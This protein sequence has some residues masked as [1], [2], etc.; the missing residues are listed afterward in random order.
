M[1]K[2]IFITG[3]K[4]MLATAIEDYYNRKGDRVLAPVH[5]ELDVLNT[6]QLKKLILSFK[7]HY[8]F[9]TAALHVDACE[10]NPELAFKLN[11]WA[12]GN[13]ARLCSDLNAVFIYVS[14]CGYFGDEIKYYSEYEPV[15]L[16]TVYSKSKYQGEVLTLRECKT[17]FAIRPGW[18]FGGSIQHKKNFVYQRYLEANDKTVVKS[19]SDKF[20]CPTLVDDLVL[21]IDEIIN[22]GHYGIY[23]LTNS[24]GCSRFEYVKKI[25]ECCGLK[26]KVIPADS[27]EFP[28]KA[29]VPSSELLYNWNL[30]Y[31][32]LSPL[33]A[34]DDAINRYVKIMFKEISA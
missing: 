20:G 26:T 2:K 8:V 9:H 22:T 32:G 4:G 17:T 12:S 28:R 1:K 34:W 16:K 19:A 13:L 27:K 25:I 18:L 6:K 31:S 15:V 11:S 3:G 14:S 7:P 24:G 29:N 33:P 23:H 21:K 5:A 10:D 30:K